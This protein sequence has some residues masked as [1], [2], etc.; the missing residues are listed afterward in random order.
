MWLAA[1]WEKKLT[2]AQIFE[3]DVPQAIEE[4]IRPK[5]KMALRTVGH[6]LLGIVRIYSKKTRYLLA[7][8][9]EAYQKMKI[10]FRNGFSFEVDIPENAEIEEDFSNFI[11]KYNI[12]VPEFH[13]ADYNEQLIM[14]NVS[15]REDITMKETVNF[16]VEFNIDADFDGFGD[17]GESWQ[18]DHLYGSVEP[19]SLRPTP[20][21]ES[22]MEVERDRD[23][24]ANGTEIS[25][26][27]ADSVIFSEGPTRPNLIFDNQEGGNF[28]PEMNLKVENQTLENDGGVGPADMFSSM[29]HPVREH[30]V[31]DVQNDDGMDFDYQPFEPENV[32]PS[33]PQSPE[34]FALEPLDVEH[35]EGR[36]K[37]Q[38]KAR[39]LIV[40]A[41]TMISNDAFREQQEDFSDTM[42]VVEMAPPTRKMFNLCVSGD[43][44]HLSR[45]PGCKMFNRELLQRYRRCLVT[46]EF[47]LNYTMQELSDS[48]S[49]TPSMEAQAEPWEDLNL[50]EDIQE[51]IQAQGPAVDEFFNDVRMDDDDDRQPAQ[52]MDFGDNFDF[53]Q[54]VEHQECAPIPIQSGFAGENKENEDAEDWS[55]PF[56]SSNSSRRGQLEAYGFGNTSTYKEDDGKWAKRAKHI[57]KKVSADIETSGQAD[58]SSVTATAK[59]R[60]QAAEQFYSLLTLAKSQAISVDQSEPYGEIV[61]R[62]G[63]NFKEACP[64]SSP[65][66][67]GL[68]NTMENSTM[69]TPMRPV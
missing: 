31:A 47:D 53:P 26:I 43:L 44:Q 24:A 65:K 55:D 39:K 13:D 40:D 56:G 41:E 30:A 34:S 37:R 15:R 61:I 28:M 63:A 23:V 58:F 25:R 20:Q 52:E 22:L 33:R 46:R 51:D 32:E 4:V 7:D 54:E 45:E 42:R 17:E 8:T 59:N 29:I 21:P 50:N 11:D 49:F 35:M 62:P 66:P 48:S 27:D 64:L 2:K 38:R 60:K 6:L 9:N 12:T 68:G 16:N 69:R 10:N 67:M 18:L 57:L 36:K 3:T 14:A 19:L 5:V 1:H